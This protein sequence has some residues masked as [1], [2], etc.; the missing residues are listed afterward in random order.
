MD[1]ADLQKRWGEELDGKVQVI[2][3]ISQEEAIE[4]F[5]K[6][7]D[8]EI[9]AIDSDSK[10]ILVVYSL[11]ALV[12]TLRSIFVGPIIPISALGFFRQKLIDSGCND[13]ECSRESLPRV[14]LET[15]DKWDF[16]K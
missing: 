4:Q 7:L 5:A 16:N 15:L 6:N 8:V 3:A 13:Y 12:S 11:L 2:S 9:I 1:N 10:E 14:I